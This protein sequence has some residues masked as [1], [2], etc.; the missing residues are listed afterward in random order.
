LE[1]KLI[2]LK[3]SHVENKTEL[4][5]ILPEEMAGAKKYPFLTE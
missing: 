1:A 4:V 5:G 2:W 3:Y